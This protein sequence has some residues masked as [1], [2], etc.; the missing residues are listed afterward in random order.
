MKKSLWLLAVVAL[1]AANAFAASYWVVLKDG[2]RY[3]CRQKWTVSNG[4]ASFTTVAGQTFNVDAGQIDAAKSDEATR[5]GGAQLIT[6]AGNGAPQA[7]TAPQQQGLGSQIRLRQ[8]PTNT[9]PPPVAN[10]STPPPVTPSSSELRAEVLQKFERAY[11]NVGIFEHKVTAT[12]AHSIRAELT[13][14]SEEKVFNAISATAFLAVRDAGVPGVKLDMV[15]LFMKTT[16]GGSSG[17]FQ[18]TRED[19]Q[20]LD[21]KQLSKEDYFVRKVIY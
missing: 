14:D 9:P 1:F 18:M 6:I 11:E 15:E 10:P 13:A 17:R 5:F 16:M 4:K 12:S 21:A 3:E 2:S 20:A 19:A 7:S 8:V